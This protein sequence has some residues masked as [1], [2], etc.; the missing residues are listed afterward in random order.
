M[1][2]VGRIACAGALGVLAAGCGEPEPDAYGN[3]EATEVT[4]SAEASGRLLRLD[5]REGT[6]LRTGQLVG[7]VDT[8][9]LALQ[10]RELLARK[11]AAGA[12]LEEVARRVDGLQAQL[13]TARQEYERDLRLF[14]EEAATARQVNLREGEVR[15][16]ERQVEATRAQ[17]RAAEEEIASV[18][19]QVE[20]VRERITDSVIENPLDG[21]VLTQ[22]ADAGE[23]VGVGQPLYDIARLDTL[24]LRAYVTEAQLARVRLGQRVTVSYDVGEDRRAS[25]PGVIT[26]V[27]SEAEFTPTPIQT[28]QERTS[29]VYAIE[30]T[31][32]NPDGAIKVGMPGEVAFRDEGPEE[33]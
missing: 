13:R 32:P 31:V 25:R 23:F 29:L 20:Q 14:E 27:A 19:A 28:R 24:E 10:R 17:R 2:R 6:T 1:R 30:V 4:V 3:F 33:P 11:R 12:R 15:A 22:F 16:L 26:K 18:D 8:T 21:V 5:A 7:L 9:S